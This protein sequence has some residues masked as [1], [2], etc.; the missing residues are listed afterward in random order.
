[1]INP[2]DELILPSIRKKS[3]IS[4]TENSSI[5]NMTHV[6]DTEREDSFC[7]QEQYLSMEGM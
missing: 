5:I 6:L 1:M 4:T 3:K 2:V 7:S